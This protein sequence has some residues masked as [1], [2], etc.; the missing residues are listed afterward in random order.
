MIFRLAS[1]IINENQYNF[2]VVQGARLSV[3]TYRLKPAQKQL[4]EY[5]WKKFGLNLKAA[6]L[7]VV[8]NCKLQKNQNNELIITFPS[9]KIDQLATLITYG[10]GKIQGCTILKEAFGRV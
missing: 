5:L 4:N 6:S 2:W 8:A 9:K 1:P 7:L 10:N 3:A